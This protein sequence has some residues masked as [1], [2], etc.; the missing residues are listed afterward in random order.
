[1]EDI[2]KFVHAVNNEK[3]EEAKKMLEKVLKDKVSK[4]IKNTL[5]PDK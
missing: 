3:I 1:M 2:E 5:N 4:K